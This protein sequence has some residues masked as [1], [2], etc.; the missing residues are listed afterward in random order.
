MPS[1]SMIMVWPDRIAQDHPTMLAGVTDA[2][3]KALVNGTRLNG[4]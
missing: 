3:L 2:I 4:S 1:Q